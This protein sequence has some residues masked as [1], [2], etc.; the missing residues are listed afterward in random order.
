MVEVGAAGLDALALAQQARAAG[1]TGRLVAL[2]QALPS[3]EARRALA[4]GFDACLALPLDGLGL[5]ACPDG[6]AI[7]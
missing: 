1:Y 6:G 3:D 5:R 4:A 7:A 2:C